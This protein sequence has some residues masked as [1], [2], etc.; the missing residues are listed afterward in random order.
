MVEQACHFVADKSIEDVRDV[1][2]REE[3]AGHYGGRL[4]VVPGDSSCY[5]LVH[6]VWV[7]GSRNSRA[8]G[9]KLMCN[10]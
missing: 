4:C 3:E 6:I 7:E 9:K 8:K 5:K 2:L 1:R 10:V